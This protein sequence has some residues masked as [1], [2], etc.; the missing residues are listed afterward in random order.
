M[1]FI[2]L[3]Y[4]IQKNV[5]DIFDSMIQTEFPQKSIF[6]QNSIKFWNFQTISKF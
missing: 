1:T 3:T 4:I 2:K 6:F 5:L